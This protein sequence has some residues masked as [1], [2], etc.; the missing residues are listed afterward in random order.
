MDDGTVIDGSTVEEIAFLS[1]SRT[2]FHALRALR[3][4]DSL[5][6]GELRDRFDASRTTVSRN[7]EALCER[8]LVAE[9]GTDYTLTRAGEVIATD[10]LDLAGTIEIARKL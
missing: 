3:E 10:L 5:T 6:K 7:L 8:G 2:R 4:A 1:G 9:I